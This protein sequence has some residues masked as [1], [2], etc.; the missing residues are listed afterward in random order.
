[1]FAIACLKS[2]FRKSRCSP[3]KRQIVT[4]GNVEVTLNLPYVLE[5]NPTNKQ[6]NN[7]SLNE[8]KIK[9]SNQGFCPFL[10]WLGMSEGITPLVWSIIAKYGAIASSFDAA[11]STLSLKNSVIASNISPN[12]LDSIDF[13][14]GRDDLNPSKGDH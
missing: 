14:N 2:N 1:M 9:T 13:L 11:R 10:K 6:P 3:K 5:R 12:E 7:S 8:Q 4:I